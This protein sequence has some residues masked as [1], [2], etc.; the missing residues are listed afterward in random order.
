M[1]YSLN[2]EIVGSKMIGATMLLSKIDRSSRSNTPEDVT[3][4]VV[5]GKYRLLLFTLE[6]ILKGRK[7]RYFNQEK[8][9]NIVSPPLLEHIKY[10]YPISAPF[11]N[12]LSSPSPPSLLSLL[13]N[14]LSS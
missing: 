7:C 8:C 5:A 14:S 2:I 4:G 11:L 1:R 10:L 6:I 9:A 12:P 13:I 3:E